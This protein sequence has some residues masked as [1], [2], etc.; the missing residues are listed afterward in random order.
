MSFE[1]PIHA[2]SDRLPRRVNN[3]TPERRTATASEALADSGDRLPSWV[4]RQD[5]SHLQHAVGN[6]AVSGLIMQREVLPG[7]R[8][9]RRKA[10][11]DE[12]AEMD[13]ANAD[14][15]AERDEEEVDPT[16]NPFA[17]LAGLESDIEPARVT[18]RKA[19]REPEKPKGPTLEMFQA[20][21]D[22]VPQLQAIA[23]G[24]IP[25]DVAKEMRRQW[26]MAWGKVGGRKF[27]TVDEL[28]RAAEK[29][30]G[31]RQD[32]EESQSIYSGSGGALNVRALK[33][34]GSKKAQKERAEFDAG[35]GATWHIHYGEHVKYGSMGETRI[36][37]GGKTKAA[38]LQELK[39][40]AAPVADKSNLQQ[41][42]TWINKNLR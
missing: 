13:R 14:W 1:E 15:E 11:D 18:P 35:T 2:V 32:A 19:V 33:G 38:V 8:K 23:F 27:T 29:S 20:A 24:D 17:A 6:R 3:A 16:V 40:R 21:G 41:C 5:V 4:T 22:S 28:K 42:R 31:V 37:F 9:R 26:R 39:E 25:A 10:E 34:I 30:L 7:R 12:L 36:N